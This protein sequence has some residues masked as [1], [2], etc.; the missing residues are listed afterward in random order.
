M[1]AWA[2]EGVLNGYWFDTKKGE[3]ACKKL[4]PK[5][6]CY[7]IDLLLLEQH[8]EG[9]DILESKPDCCINRGTLL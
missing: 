2:T 1:K 5:G 9:R 6:F 8:P 7:K 3:L 4:A